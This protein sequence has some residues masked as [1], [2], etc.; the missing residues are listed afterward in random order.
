MK[1]E[2]ILLAT[3]NFAS[4]NILGRGGYGIVYKGVWKH[5]DVAVKRI[6]SRKDSNTEVFKQKKFIK[7]KNFLATKRKNS[8]KFTR[9]S[10]FGEI[11]SR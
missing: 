10:N 6:Q 9:G 5:I 1:Y 8:P 4:E 7:L 11:S 3:N 2:D